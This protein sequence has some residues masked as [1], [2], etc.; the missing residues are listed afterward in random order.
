MWRALSLL[1][2]ALIPS[3]R[4]F[5]LIAPSPRIEFRLL[6][7][8]DAPADGWREFRPRPARISFVQMLVRLI[9]NPAWNESLFL[10]S[11]AERLLDEP[12]DHSRIEIERRIAAEVTRA[13]PDATPFLQFRLI[14][15]ARDGAKLTRSVA[16]LSAPYVCA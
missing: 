13:M 4:F 14:L 10:V 7:D 15:I 6:H 12:S 1:L 2:P 11:C 9:W 3:W 5:D 16:Y 8:V